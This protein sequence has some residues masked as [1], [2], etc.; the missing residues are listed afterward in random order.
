M[1]LPKGSNL[2]SGLHRCSRHL[3]DNFSHSAMTGTQIHILMTDRFH[4]PLYLGRASLVVL[5]NVRQSIIKNM[6]VVVDY[7]V[8]ACDV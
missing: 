3:Q 6:E 5:V 2:S 7:E 4:H 8:I 1:I